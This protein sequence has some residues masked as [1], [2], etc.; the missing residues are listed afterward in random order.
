MHTFIKVGIFW[1]VIERLEEGQLNDEEKYYI[2]SFYSAF[3]T[4]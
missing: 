1:T 2:G 4:Q 3:K